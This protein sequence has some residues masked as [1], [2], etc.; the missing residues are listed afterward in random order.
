MAPP[1]KSRTQALDRI[2]AIHSV[3]E[4]IPR[5]LHPLSVRGA[6][7]FATR[8]K[9]CTRPPGSPGPKLWTAFPRSILSGSL[10]RGFYTRGAF[11]EQNVLQPV[12]SIAPARLTPNLANSRLWKSPQPEALPF[13]ERLPSLLAPASPALSLLLAALR[14]TIHHAPAKSCAKRDFLSSA[15]SRSLS[16]PF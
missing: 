6:K 13:R 15:V 8:A 16:W 2:S 4:L 3:R 1:W 9:H 7:R 14:I 12:R 11:A 5:I 10:Y